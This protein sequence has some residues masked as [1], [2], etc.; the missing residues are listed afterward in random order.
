MVFVHLYP[1]LPGHIAGQLSAQAYGIPVWVAVELRAQL[2]HCLGDLFDD[3]LAG[4]IRVLVGIELVSHLELR[5]AVSG[6]TAQLLTDRQIR[7]LCHGVNP[8]GLI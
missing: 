6:L 1:G 2:S 4:C 5:C 3:R 8:S 7:K